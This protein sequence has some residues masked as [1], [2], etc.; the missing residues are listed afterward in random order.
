LHP[1]QT[2][3]K[4]TIAAAADRKKSQWRKGV[5]K[6]T[7]SPGPFL[8]GEKFAGTKLAGLALAIQTSKRRSH[9]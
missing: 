8:L 4:D 5:V 3:P 6:I 7:L 1:Y 9:P 2:A